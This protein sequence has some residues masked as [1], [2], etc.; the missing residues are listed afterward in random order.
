MM[1]YNRLSFKKPRSV[2]LWK[3]FFKKRDCK[4]FDAIFEL[5]EKRLKYYTKGKK[6]NQL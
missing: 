4:F 3:N 1:L 6:D 5:N 2:M